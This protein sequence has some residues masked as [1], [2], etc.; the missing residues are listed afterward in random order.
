M[1]NNFS[2]FLFSFWPKKSKTGITKDIVNIAI[3][4]IVGFLGQIL[5]EIVDIYWI[6]KL[7]GEVIAA[8]AAAAFWHWT[9]FAIMNVT[10]TG[11]ASL[12][13]QYYGSNDIRSRFQVIKESFW[14]SLIVTFLMMLFFLLFSSKIFQLMGLS[15]ASHQYA[16]DYFLIFVWGLP[17]LYLMSLTGQIFN[18]YGDTKTSTLIMGIVI[19]L[20]I[21]LDPLLIF[22]Y[23]GFPKL[24]IQGASWALI[25]SEIIGTVFRLY[26]LRKKNYI[27]ELFSF[28]DIKNFSAQFF[29]KILHIGVP[30]ALTNVIWTLVFPTLTILITK[31]G[32]DPL[33]GLNVG[34][35]IE[36][37]PYFFGIGFSIAMTALVG[38]S[39]GQNDFEKIKKIINR[40]MILISLFMF[41]V[42]ISFIFFPEFFVKFLVTDP[43]VIHHAANYLRIV[44]YFEF[45]LGWELIIEGIFNGLGKTRTYMF[46]RIPL[47]LLRIPLAYLFAFTFGMGVSGV[48]WAISIT[49]FFKGVGVYI[50]LRYEIANT[51]D[52]LWKIL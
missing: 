28:V 29:K 25:I 14:L 35:R 23:F 50:A 20:N 30:S 27:P 44:G 26:F 16:L 18:A 13:A 42:A 3:P 38:Q 48:W 22:G 46:V 43:N 37:F 31:F 52:T 17:I 32:M 4:S 36:G 12:V 15:T 49:T 8:V 24:G 39:F 1:I 7:G 41:P 51:K 5:F 6:G 47:T 10:T 2:H 34:N 45:F 33:A 19:V 21:I 11:A 40:G 9:T